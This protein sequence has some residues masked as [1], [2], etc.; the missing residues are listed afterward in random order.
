MKSIFYILLQIL[1][2]CPPLFCPSLLFGNELEITDSELELLNELDQ[3]RTAD[4]ISASKGQVDPASALEPKV[5]S[6]EKKSKG[7]H[8]K[9][10]Q[11][12]PILLRH[13][14]D[15]ENSEGFKYNLGTYKIKIGASKPSFQGGL[16]YYEDLYGAP[17]IGATMK[18]DYFFLDDVM[19]LG[20]GLHLGYSQDTGHPAQTNSPS[21]GGA[22]E[23]EELDSNQDL[24]LVL[25]P[26]QFNLVAQWPLFQK[27]VVLDA[28]AG[29]E[30]LYFQES[31][32]SQAE[33]EGSTGGDTFVNTGRNYSYVFGGG[34]NLRI[35]QLESGN[36]RSLKNMGIQAIY[37]MPYYEVAKSFKSSLK[38]GD[39]SRNSAG[40]LF[41]FETI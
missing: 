31:R 24:L 14:K 23:Q 40:I 13:D 29:I 15:S 18:F 8:A 28:W 27:F 35:D 26:I 33:S 6:V 25:M 7:L 38:G 36:G 11:K 41:S 20:V 34:I 21:S 10:N 1:I 12:G 4:P 16:R 2:Y 19:P 5:G 17:P 22:F 30:Y 39:F 37:L 9:I 32:H 3:L